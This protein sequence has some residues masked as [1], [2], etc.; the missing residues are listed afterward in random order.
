M[1]SSKS[2]EVLTTRKKFDSGEG[3]REKPKRLKSDADN[4]EKTEKQ[5]ES[6]DNEAKKRSYDLVTFSKLTLS[7]QVLK[8]YELLNKPIPTQSQL[9]EAK[10]KKKLGEKD[11]K[12]Q[13]GDKNANSN[14]PQLILDDNTSQK[15]NIGWWYS[16]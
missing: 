3:S 4:E 8:R 9:A 12:K 13:V 1:Q 10:L 5:G 15:V 6:S 11:A 16:I 7:Q 2:E 14:T